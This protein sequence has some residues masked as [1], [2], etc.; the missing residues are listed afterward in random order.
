TRFELNRAA[1]SLHYPHGSSLAVSLAGARAVHRY[2]ADKHG[3][4]VMRMLPM[5]GGALN[6][7]TFN[8]VVTARGLPDCGE[9]LRQRAAAPTAPRP[10]Q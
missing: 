5:L 6:F 8:D 1:G 4:P 9:Y 2:V 7:L 10:G 3:T